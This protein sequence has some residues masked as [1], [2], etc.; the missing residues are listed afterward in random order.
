MLSWL[1]GRDSTAADS[2]S[3]TE[4]EQDTA[5][6]RAFVQ[7]LPLTNGEAEFEEKAEK[8]DLAV[9]ILWTANCAAGARAQCESVVSR[10][11]R[12]S[13][14]AASTASTSKSRNI[15]RTT[16]SAFSLK[17]SSEKELD[18]VQKKVKARITHLPAVVFLE[19]GGPGGSS[20]TG[21]AAASFQEQ[22]GGGLVTGANVPQ[23]ILHAEAL[24]HVFYSTS[25]SSSSNKT[26]FFFP[27]SRAAANDKPSSTRTVTNPRYPREKLE[28]AEVTSPTTPGAAAGSTLSAG[29]STSSSSRTTGD[30]ALDTRCAAEISKEKVVLFMKGNKDQPKCG[31]SKKAVALLND[32]IGEKAYATFDILQ[33]EEIRQ[34]LKKYSAWPTYP[35]L[36][37]HA[38]LQGGLDV[39]KEMADDGSLMELL[40]TSTP[41]ED[42][43]NPDNL[44]PDELEMKHRL[45]PLLNQSTVMLFMKGNPG[46]PKC[47]FSRKAVAVL[48]EYCGRTG[49]NTFDILTDEWVRQKLKEYSNWPTYPQLYIKGELIGGLDIINEAVRDGSLE[50]AILEAR[51]GA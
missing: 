25:L 30:P 46:N 3:D 40:K 13:S 33:D 45:E 49:Y 29:G 34:G 39:M 50:E 18:W 43:N 48:D 19:R 44:S 21:R 12:K 20:T 1:L 8:S 27:S 4:D 47:G 6:S 11:P 2:G 26:S 23:I 10:L 7:I 24:G 22:S 38:E 17:L 14:A 42:E 32:L 35:Q 28:L 15:R 16:L 31:F 51:S 41:E 9:L 36:Y 37:V 5:G